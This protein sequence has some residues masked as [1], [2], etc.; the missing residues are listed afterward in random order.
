MGLINLTQNAMEQ[1]KSKHETVLLIYKRAFYGWH[2]STPEGCPLFTHQPAIA[3]LHP[4][5]QPRDIALALQYSPL[6][7][8]A[9]NGRRA[10]VQ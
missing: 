10:V 4:S 9:W 5:V 3:V 1:F 8:L 7:L 6:I 2:V